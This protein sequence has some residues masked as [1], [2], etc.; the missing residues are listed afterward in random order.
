[1]IPRSPADF[2]PRRPGLAWARLALGCNPAAG[3][4]FCSFAAGAA[5]F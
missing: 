2:A 3:V 1:M 5:A 4:E